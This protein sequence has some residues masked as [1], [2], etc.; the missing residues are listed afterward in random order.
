[1]T[2]RQRERRRY[3]ASVVVI[4]TSKNY[5]HKET[6][7]RAGSIWTGCGQIQRVGR[8]LAMT[9]PAREVAVVNSKSATRSDA[10]A[11]PRFSAG[12]RAGTKITFGHVLLRS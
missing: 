3:T 2:V 4:D 1:V 11:I 6:P 9:L 12:R 5:R 8:R 7:T 10:H